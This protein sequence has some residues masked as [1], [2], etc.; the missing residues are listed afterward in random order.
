MTVSLNLDKSTYRFIPTSCLTINKSNIERFTLK[1]HSA[2]QIS[3]IFEN[4]IKNTFMIRESLTQPGALTLARKSNDEIKNYRYID[5][6][7]LMRKLQAMISARKSI[8]VKDDKELLS[9][10]DIEKIKSKAYGS[11]SP[12]EANQILANQENGT[13]LLRRSSRNNE[14]DDFFSVT[15]KSEFGTIQHQRLSRNETPYT[16]TQI[17]ENL[18]QLE[19]L[20]GLTNFLPLRTQIKSA[21]K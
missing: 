18:R 6:Q 7:D 3:T 5:N 19:F 2:A 4:S 8:I 15:W 10:D 13:Y 9:N 1:N 21:R 12:Q 11:L 16:N 14:N 17:A 20:F